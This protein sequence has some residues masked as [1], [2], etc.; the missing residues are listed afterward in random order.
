MLKLL[1]IDDEKDFSRIISKEYVPMG[2]EVYIAE[3]GEEGL[4]KFAEVRPDIVIVD[5]KLPDIAGVDVVKKIR[6]DGNDVLL[7]MVTVDREEHVLE[8]IRPYQVDKYMKKPFKLLELKDSLIGLMGEA[9]KRKKE[10]G[11]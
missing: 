7:F 10:L 1:V 6:A 11:A 8:A 5:N 3:T 2:C 9:I 4:K